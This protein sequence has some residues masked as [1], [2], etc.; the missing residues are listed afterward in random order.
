MRD[1]PGA[2]LEIVKRPDLRNQIVRQGAIPSTSTP[3]EYRQRMQ[4]ESD[5]RLAVIRAGGIR[6][7]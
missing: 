2:R 6:L 7:Q 4:A 5:K 1:H 3:E